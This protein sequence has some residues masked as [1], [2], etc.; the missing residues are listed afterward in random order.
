[1]PWKGQETERGQLW[2]SDDGGDTWQVVS[3]DHNAMGRAHYYSRMAVAPDDPDE[4]YFLTASFSKSIDGGRTITPLPQRG[5]PRPGMPPGG[6]HHDIWI[7]PTN[8]NR[9]IVAHDQGLSI[10]INRGKTWYRQ[11]LE[12]RA[13]LP[14]HR[15]QRD[16]LQRARQ[17][18]G[19][20][21]LSRAE[22][23]PAAGRLR[24]RSPASRAA[25]WHAVGGGESG[26]ATPD[27]KDSNIV[28]S[29]ASGSGM[30]GG[31]V[32]RFEQNRRQFRNVEVWP[33]QS[34]GPAEGVRYRFVWDAPLQISPH[35]SNTI[36]VGSQHVHRTTN[37]GQSWEVISPDLTLNDRSRDGQL[38]RSDA[39]QHRRRVR[40][41]R[42]RHRR[43]AAGA[44]A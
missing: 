23:Q 15:R 12:E 9:Q 13:D 4:A 44:R 31:I 16:S 29:T 28:W 40:R 17:Q 18:A 32:V 22:Q 24:R 27:P 30:V 3:Y 2:R 7:D 26:W 34:N 35:D 25:M 11:R 43:V 19:R 36:Y 21:D 33:D 42:L 10:T 39:R 37:G 8:A 14:R 41:R 5:R 1:M 38:R 20:A 6:D